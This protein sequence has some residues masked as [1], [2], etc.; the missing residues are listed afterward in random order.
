MGF[1]SATAF[2][3]KHGAAASIL[4]AGL[5]VCPVKPPPQVYVHFAAEK[6]LYNT[7]FSGTQLAQ[8][9]TTPSGTSF[10]SHKGASSG[11]DFLDGVTMR[12]L[13]HRLRMGFNT[14]TDQDGKSCLYFE[15]ATFIITYQASV[16][17]AKEIT[18]DKCYADVVR[19][20]ENRHIIIDIDTIREMIPSI[21]IELLQHIRNIGYQGIGPVTAEQRTAKRKEMKR[22]LAAAARPL[23]RQLR[24]QVAQRQNKIDT[25]ENLAQE[26]AHCGSKTD[27]PENTPPK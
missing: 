7:D 11:T 25:P 27:A 5:V 17:I 14:W 9:M 26:E 16:F 23:V 18:D 24:L 19:A 12:Q 13:G 3:L 2:L 15:H 4:S 1:L 10:A 6:T 20:H 21:K 22:Q 8:G